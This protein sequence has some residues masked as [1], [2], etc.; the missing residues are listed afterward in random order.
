VAEIVAAIPGTVFELFRRWR[1]DVVQIA[2]RGFLG[3]I[4]KQK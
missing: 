2:S 3:V 4:A 1:V